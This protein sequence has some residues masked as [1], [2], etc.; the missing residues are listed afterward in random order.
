MIEALQEMPLGQVRIEW[1][2]SSLPAAAGRL[3]D[4]RG[5]LAKRSNRGGRLAG[6]V[7]DTG[8]QRLHCAGKALTGVRRFLL[9]SVQ[10]R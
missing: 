6:P 8:W 3:V 5:V 10:L 7:D 2:G 1:D 9:L 4:I